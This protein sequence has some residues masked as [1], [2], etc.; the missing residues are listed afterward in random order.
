MPAAASPLLIL[1]A[2]AGARAILYASGKIENFNAA[3]A[4]LHIYA[5]GAG[6]V[7]LIGG[8]AINQIIVARFLDILGGGA[9]RA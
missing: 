8:E 1:N 5:E 2:R 9:G 6:L 7:E 4:P 3:I